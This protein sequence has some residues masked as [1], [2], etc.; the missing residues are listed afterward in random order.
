MWRSSVSA[1]GG[2]ALQGGEERP[3]R[4][5]V[6][7]VVRGREAGAPRCPAPPRAAPAE[8]ARQAPV[9]ALVAPLD[10]A[11]PV[12]LL[13]GLVEGAPEL[14]DVVADAVGR[15]ARARRP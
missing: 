1:Y 14:Y 5:T 11:A 7:R 12:R 3:Y 13:D 15:L 6:R 4:V 10:R 8:V 9:P 2:P